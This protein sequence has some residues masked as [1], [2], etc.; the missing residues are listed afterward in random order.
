MDFLKDAGFATLQAAHA[1]AAME[2]LQERQPDL[3]LLFTDVHMPGEMDGFALVRHAA[4]RRPHI[5]IASG[6]AKPGSGD[7]HG[8]ASESFSPAR[9]SLDQTFAW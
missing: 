9:S 1:D 8:R 6:E 7:L 4:G 3:S 2:L 5:A